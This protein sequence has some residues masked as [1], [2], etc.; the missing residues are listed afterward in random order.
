MDG[1]NR[2]R[3]VNKGYLAIASAVF[4]AGAI[5]AAHAQTS[6]SEQSAMA[7]KSALEQYRDMTDNERAALINEATAK[8]LAPTRAATAAERAML[9]ESPASARA[10]MYVKPESLAKSGGNGVG[11]EMRVGNSV[12]KVLG[13]A[14]FNSR[15]MTLTADGKH[16]E[17]CETGAHA[18]DATTKKLLSDASRAAAKGATRE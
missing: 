13:T 5:G 2:K 11:R 9:A 1:L 6:K 4:A 8:V 7:E 14:F 17:A 16:F 18:H 10:R 12:G 3:V 15:T